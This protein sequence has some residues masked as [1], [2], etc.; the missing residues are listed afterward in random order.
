MRSSIAMAR[1]DWL[2]AERL[3]RASH[4]ALDAT[5]LRD[6]ATA[7]HVHGVAARVA[8]HRGDGVRGRE[9]LVHAQLIRPLAS[10]ALPW[11]AVSALTEVARAYLS[12]ADAAGARTAVAEAEAVLRQRPALGLLADRLV[13]VRMQA[14][15]AASSMAGPST[16]TPAELRVL[17]LLS[18]HLTFQEI[19]DRLSN[20]RS[21]IHSHAVSIYAKL[22]VTGRSE[23]VER[24]IALGL[25]EPFPGLGL[26]TSSQ[27][28]PD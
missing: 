21:T 14:D 10:Y 18:T 6:V 26:T 2:A 24:A 13:D 23:A 12:I 11:I 1:G 8:I 27:H 9:E 25:L 28:R 16:L 20:S 4:D 5:H 15:A 19:A 22:E 3:A 17:P 7:I